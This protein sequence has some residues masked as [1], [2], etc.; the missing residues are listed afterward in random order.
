[1]F[2]FLTKIKEDA[3]KVSYKFETNISS[4]VYKNPVGHKRDFA[5]VVYGFCTFD[6]ETQECHLDNGTDPYFIKINP[7]REAVF[8]KL[9]EIAQSG[10][11]F[12][13]ELSLHRE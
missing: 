10:Q 7:E 8:E 4:A 12:P 11:N 9:R 2:V 3:K 1:M 13:E 5:E 6:K